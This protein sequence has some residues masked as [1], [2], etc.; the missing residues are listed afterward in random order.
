MSNRV[1]P[2]CSTLAFRQASSFTVVAGTSL[3]RLCPVTY[4]VWSPS[5]QAFTVWVPRQV[6]KDQGYQWLRAPPCMEEGAQK[7]A[8][9]AAH[10]GNNSLD[11]KHFA[12]LEDP[13][14]KHDDQGAA[15]I[16]LDCLCTLMQRMKWH[17]GGE[18]QHASLDACKGATSSR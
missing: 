18:E 16:I 13:Q 14:T 7:Y 6:I 10:T 4:H 11:T 3:H 17:A 5:A 9:C 1:L 15:H 2:T 12:L 8:R